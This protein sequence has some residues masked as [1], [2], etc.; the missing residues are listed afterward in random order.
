MPS[1][2]TEFKVQCGLGGQFQ[3]P[4]DGW[5]ICDD[6]KPET[7]ENYPEPP[8]IIEFVKK[9]PQYAGGK[10]LYKCKEPGFISNIG[11]MIEVTCERNLDGTLDFV[12]PNG[13]NNLK[14]RSAV[15]PDFR[16]DPCICPGDA[17]LTKEQHKDI[18]DICYEEE[19]LQTRAS[20][21]VPLKKRCGVG[22]LNN[23]TKENMC[24]CTERKDAAAGIHLSKN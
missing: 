24:Y 21:N 12:L 15:Y 13:W 22:A 16:Q 10:I 9:M 18:L 23:V 3:L 20:M 17:E 19:D 14:C 6:E 1:G 5:P 11:D 8:D 4:S 2:T 7:C